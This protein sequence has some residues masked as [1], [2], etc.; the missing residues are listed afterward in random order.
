[1]DDNSPDCWDVLTGSSSSR[2][3][4]PSELME[5]RNELEAMATSERGRRLEDGSKTAAGLQDGCWDDR[6]DSRW[7]G[8]GEGGCSASEQ[9]P[10]S[11][12]EGAAPL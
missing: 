8:R 1:M 9:R 3:L 7:T 10:Y 2:R 11:R 6:R 4:Q 5:S 12:G